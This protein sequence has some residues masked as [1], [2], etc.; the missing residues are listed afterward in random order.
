[1]LL[2]SNLNKRIL[3]LSEPYC[4][5]VHDYNMMK[6]EFDP[7]EGLWFNEHGLFLD[8]GFYGIKKDYEIKQLFIPFKRQKRKSKKDP[9]IELTENQK[10][11]NKSVSK[12]RIIVEH[13]IAGLKRYRFLSDRLRCRDSAFY[14]KVA[15]IAAGLW[16]FQLTH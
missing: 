3:Y 12:I 9:K 5:S 1:L 13:A 8:L 16:N 10:M 6:S 14:S 7:D 2:I 15:G 11:Y 4:G